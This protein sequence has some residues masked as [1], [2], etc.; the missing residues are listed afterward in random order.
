MA[1]ESISSRT[2]TAG[3]TI[4]QFARVKL[5]AAN[6]VVVSVA[7]D[8]A[9]YLG[10][11]QTGAASGEELTV[12]LKGG[13][14]TFKCIANAA[15]SVNAYFYS[16]ADGEIAPGVNGSPIGTALEASTADQDIIEC[17]LLDQ[18]AVVV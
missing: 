18:V 16:A 5:S 2:F 1:T 11:A 12:A 6:T 15:I 3:G 7:A 14:R 4:P 17:V 10:V 8:K 9:A 13:Y